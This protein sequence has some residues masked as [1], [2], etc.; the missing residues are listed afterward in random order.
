M[1]TTRAAWTRGGTSNAGYA[2]FVDDDI[3]LT[4]ER[5]AVTPEQI[6]SGWTPG[7]PSNPTPAQRNSSAIGRG[8]RHPIVDTA[9]PWYVRPSN[10]GST[11]RSVAGSPRSLKRSEKRNRFRRSP[12]TGTDSSSTTGLRRAVGRYDRH[13]PIRRHGAARG[14][15]RGS[16]SGKYA[17]PRHNEAPG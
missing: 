9:R 7:R 13:R 1:T 2:D 10:T 14:K 5:I 8:R 3:E 16:Q 12:V 11:R 15:A 4:F 17:T 6:I